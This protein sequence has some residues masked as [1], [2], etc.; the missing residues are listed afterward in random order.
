MEI[1]EIETYLN[2]HD[3]QDRLK[4][5]SELKNYDTETAVPLLKSKMRDPEFLV[6]S[7][8][9]MGFAKKQTADSFAALLEMLNFDRDSN[10]RAEA[11]NSLSLF[12]KVAASHLVL[13][14]NRDEHWLLR[15]SI[16]AAL[17]ELNCTE[18]LF[19]VCVCGI[20]GEDFAVRESSLEALGLLANTTKQEVA[21]EKILAFVQS[22]E[23]RIR[24]RV[25]KA[26]SRFDTPQAKES[27]IQLK[28]DEDHRVVGA[29]LEGLL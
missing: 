22:E 18:E 3:L 28:Q 7:F 4:A 9:A 2:S 16:L 23:W 10:V 21:L 17:V 19:D 27:L 12:G 25:A 24:L 13:A 11:A 6:R 8:V 29:A 14:F 15:L 1:N 26:L 5:I 20:K